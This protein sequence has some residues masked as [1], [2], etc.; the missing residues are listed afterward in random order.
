MLE[1][2]MDGEENDMEVYIKDMEKPTSCNKCPF[3]CEVLQFFNG[4]DIPHSCPLIEIVTCGECKHSKEWYADR[5][6][7]Y[8]WAEEGVSVFEDGF[9]NYGERRTEDFDPYQGERD[10]DENGEIY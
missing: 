4:K 3:T 2:R 7:C 6:L 8:L 1:H 5:C 9:C 10:R